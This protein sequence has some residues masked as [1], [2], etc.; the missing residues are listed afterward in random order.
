MNRKLFITLSFGLAF[1]L[2]ACSSSN[3]SGTTAGG[4]TT[5]PDA[6]PGGTGGT[7]GNGGSDGNQR[8]AVP[9]VNTALSAAEKAVSDAVG[10]A[11]TVSTPT[12]R[13]NAARLIAQ[14]RARLNDAVEAA[15]NAVA[16]AQG[17]QALGEATQALDRATSYRSAQEE[18]LNTARASFA[19]YGRQLVR[20]AFAR[21]TVAIPRAGNTAMIRRIPRTIPSPT[22]PDT[23]IVNPDAFCDDVSLP[24]CTSTTFKDIMYSD[25]KRVFSVADDDE[26]GDE[27]KVN[28]YVGWTASSSTLDETTHTGLKLTDAGLVIRT[29]GTAASGADR[30]RADFTDMRRKITTWASD[31]DSDGDVD[32]ADGIR[33]QNGWDLEIT[34]DEPQ[35]PRSVPVS[36]SDISDPVSSWSGNN[37]FYWKSVVQADSEQTSK[38]GDY[39][40]ANAFRQPKGSEDLG[41]YEVWLSNHIGVDTN[42]EPAEGQGE[43]T[44]LDRSRGTSC[45][46]DDEHFYLNYAAYGLFVYTA[47]TETFNQGDNGQVGRIN[48]LSFGYS[49]FGTE[50]GQKTKDIGEAITGGRFHGHTLAYEILG[51]Q[52]LQLG[53]T[54][55]IET[56]LLRGDVTLTVNIPKGS[57]TGYLQGTMNNFQQWN[58][59]NKVWTAY[60]DN[61]KVVLNPTT[62]DNFSESGS[63]SGTTTATPT[64]VTGTTFNLGGGTGVYK[65]SF[66]GPRADVKDLEIA[67]SWT[68]GSGDADDDEQDIYGSFGAK[69]RPAATPGSS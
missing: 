55:G 26:G 22:D 18:I 60:V 33:G 65:G 25:D 39:Y 67:G 53:R 50:E 15:R 36:Y 34:F 13:A 46:F 63:F 40:D 56:K 27:F 17:P 58:E 11:R 45:P 49:A 57:G 32:A 51:D 69:Q 31:S 59:E 24:T 66:Y 3:T 64:T 41:T 38:D 68:V 8:T 9:A 2:G 35:Q 7:D 16:A 47:S 21:G 54:T 1:L 28:G 52:N 42:T 61:F 43:V 30:F 6:G 19:W 12:E 20:Y 10:A 14:A 4:S 44:C 5:P 29:G 62:T 37:A 23:Q 48:T